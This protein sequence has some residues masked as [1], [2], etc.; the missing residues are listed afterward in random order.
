M[1]NVTVSAEQE[2]KPTRED[3]KS[4]LDAK[5]E[6]KLLRGLIGDLE[7][8]IFICKHCDE[9]VRRDLSELIAKKEML[10]REW[11]KRCESMLDFML[12]MERFINECVD[13][14]DAP[15]M[16]LLYFEGKTWWEVKHTS[17]MFNNANILRVFKKYGLASAQS[18]EATGKKRSK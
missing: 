3:L 7:D 11:A 10:L 4:Y 1:D 8:E 16:R 14:K 13:K 2:H 12:N 15:I 5:H 9:A 18:W 6:C 17:K